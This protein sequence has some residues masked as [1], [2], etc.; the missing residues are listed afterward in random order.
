MRGLT[1]LKVEHARPT[2]K[3]RE[4]PDKGKPGLFLVIQP[5]GYKSWC[6]RYRRLSDK[7]PC[8]LVLPGGLVS[9]ATARRL[10]QQALD[11][12]AEGGDP[13]AQKQIDK[14]T[15]HEEGDDF[16]GTVA[17]LIKRDQSS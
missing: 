4:I 6:V 1:S 9:L 8:K 3:R 15:A 5:S 2:E 16:A 17:L 7:K 11:A 10:A 12:V 14:R 13:A